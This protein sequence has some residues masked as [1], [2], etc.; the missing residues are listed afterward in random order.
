[1]KNIKAII[2]VAVLAAPFSLQAAQPARV[3]IV[4]GQSDYPY[5]DWRSTTPFLKKAL[6][7]TGRFDLWVTEEPSGITRAALAHYDAVVLNYNG[8]RWGSAAEAALEQFVRSGKGLVSL[9]GAAYGPLM[10][11][12]PSPGGGW[13]RRRD[14]LRS[15]RCWA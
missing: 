8:P 1:M 2:R 11:T 9:Q 15:A 14:G 13:N 5:H 4:T 6:E 7:D 12:V 3:L 10:G